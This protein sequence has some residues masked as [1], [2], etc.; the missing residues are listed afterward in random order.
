MKKLKF[1]K[2]ITGTCLISMIVFPILFLLLKSSL[3]DV[4]IEV[5]ALKREITKEE[6]KIESLSM[7]I[8]ELKSLANISDAIENEGL[9]YNSTN[10][11]VISKK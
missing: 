1:S 3:S 6:N 7:K 5:E 8:D 4:N 10:I 9:G 2:L 11:K